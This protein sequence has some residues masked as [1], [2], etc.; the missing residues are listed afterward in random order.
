MQT[1]Q[2]PAESC[3]QLYLRPL[4]MTDEAVSKTITQEFL[5]TSFTFFFNADMSWQENLQQCANEA[6]GL[7]LPEGRVRAEFLVGVVDEEIVG[8][9][10]IRYD[11][12][13]YLKQYGGHVG[14]AVRPQFRH[15][16]YAKQMLQMAVVRLAQAGV[17]NVLVT[18]DESNIA[19]QKTIEACGGVLENIVEQPHEAERKCRYWICAHK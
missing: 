13:D 10:S 2:H 12:N 9:I 19:S 6:A 3:H 14:Y 5:D 15:R 11:L 16:G 1:H 18:C 8:R 17:S 7:S 4:I